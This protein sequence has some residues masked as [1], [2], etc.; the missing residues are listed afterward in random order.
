MNDYSDSTAHPYVNRSV[1][2]PLL[3]LLFFLG[4]IYFGLFDTTVAIAIHFALLTVRQL[5]D[6]QRKSNSSRIECR[7]AISIYRLPYTKRLVGSYQ[8]QHIKSSFDSLLSAHQHS[9]S[10]SYTHLTLPTNREV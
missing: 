10:V 4:I 3:C 5:K 9:R 7:F 6:S 8:I 2:S 1:I